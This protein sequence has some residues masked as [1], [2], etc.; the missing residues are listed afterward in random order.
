[1]FRPYLPQGD[2]RLA[3]WPGNR[4]SKDHTGVPG[5][6]VDG[7]PGRDLK[8][9]LPP[10]RICEVLKE[11]AR[12]DFRS[13]PLV[14]LEKELAAAG[15]SPYRAG[16]L[17]RW[18]YKKRVEDF[19]LVT[20]LA[21]VARLF[22]A[23]RFHFP[24]LEVVRRQVS[25]D[26][27]EKCLFRLADGLAIE[28]VLIPEGKRLTLCVSTQVGC[29]FGCRFCCSGRWGWK[30]DLVAGE[31][32]AQFLAV[33]DLVAPRSITNLVFMGVGEPLDNLGETLKAVDVLTEPA[34]IY[35][36]KRKVCLSTCGLVEPLKKLVA[37]SPAFKIALSLH[38][39]DD[40]V[41]SELM[42][43]NRSNP[44]SLI[45]KILEPWAR[46]TP[47][48]LT[49]EYTLIRGLNA[50]SRD[51]LGLS[52]LAAHLRAKVNLIPCHS[53]GSGFDPPSP[54]EQKRFRDEL[55]R[56]EIFVTLRKSRGE[57]IQAACGQLGIAS[58]KNH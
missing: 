19:A 32:V 7:R 25:R 12:Q 55:V 11:L 35:L 24:A 1:M 15:L 42:P 33:V 20:D 31:I 51:A 41:R 44:L 37:L 38:S 16:Q 52:R 22:L 39:T 49:L 47:R 17:Y 14:D 10:P 56:R 8:R 36:G 9:A 57:D 50:F 5:S 26:G 27:A 4:F 6:P 29:R 3:Y 21:K 53:T 58:I 43:V 28:T 54:E 40:S 45:A 2:C 23:G 13:L 18:V 46:K 34:G 48:S 30:R